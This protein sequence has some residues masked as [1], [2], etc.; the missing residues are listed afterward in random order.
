MTATVVPGFVFIFVAT[1]IFR[2]LAAA[3]A[4]CLSAPVNRPRTDACPR[5]LG[6]NQLSANSRLPPATCNDSLPEGAHTPDV[7]TTRIAKDPLDL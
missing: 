7:D 4:G 1:L 6:C 5:R 3:S 2:F